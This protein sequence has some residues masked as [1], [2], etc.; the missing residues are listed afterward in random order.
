M[1]RDQEASLAAASHVAGRHADRIR[2]RNVRCKI[3]SEFHAHSAQLPTTGHP[4]GDDCHDE[5]RSHQDAFSFR[6]RKPT[7]W[8]ESI[9][10][11]LSEGRKLNSRSSSVM[12]AAVTFWVPMDSAAPATAAVGH[13]RQATIRLLILPHGRRKTRDLP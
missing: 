7:S 11:R 10:S 12:K 3:N 5:Y 2:D 4:D 13:A 1:T 8:S 6:P 9:C